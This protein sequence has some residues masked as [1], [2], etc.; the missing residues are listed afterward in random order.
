MTCDCP[1]CDAHTHHAAVAIKELLTCEDNSLDD[2]EEVM[3][4]VEQYTAHAINE[5]HSE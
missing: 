4:Y 2:A 1:S 3:E 5:E